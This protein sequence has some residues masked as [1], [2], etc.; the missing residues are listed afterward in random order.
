MTTMDFEK[1]SQ[2]R[3]AKAAVIEET[4]AVDGAWKQLMPSVKA[5][6]S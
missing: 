1:I 5:E 3:T 2:Q 4:A 6:L